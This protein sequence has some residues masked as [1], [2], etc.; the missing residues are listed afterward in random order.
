MFRRIDCNRR[1]GCAVRVKTVNYGNL[2]IMKRMYSISMLTLAAACCAAFTVNAQSGALPSS[3]NVPF[4][5]GEVNSTP[6][7]IFTNDQLTPPAASANGEVFSVA[8]GNWSDP[9]V[10]DC[11]CVPGITHDVTIMTG[12][13]VFMATSAAAVNLVIEPGGILAGSE[14]QSVELNLVGDLDNSGDFQPGNATVRMS[15]EV[16]QQIGGPIEI[17]ELSIENAAGVDAVGLVDV[18]GTLYVSGVLNT[19]DA[20][21]LLSSGVGTSANLAPVMGGTVNGQLT[22]ERTVQTPFA[23]WLT[24]GS[25]FTDATLEE[26]NDDFVTTGF[27]GSDFPDFSFVS[28]RTYNEEP[29]VG[30]ESFQSVSD[31]TEAIAPGEGYYLYSNPGTYTFDISGLPVIGNFTFPVSFTDHG[32]PSEDG[33]NLV[34]NPYA[35]NI[36][37]ASE[38]GW[39]KNNMHGV[40]YIWDVGLNQFRTYSNGYGVNGGSPLIRSGEAFWVHA[41]GPS[42]ELTV[43]ESAKVGADFDPSVN[44][45][46]QYL[47]FR[48]TGLGLGDEIIVAFD[49]NATEGF[50]P[51]I[52]AF[53]FF[54]SN[55]VI[56][57]A[58]VTPDGTRLAINNI[59]NDENPMSVPILITAAEAGT[60]TIDIQNLP[61][62]TNRCIYLE[63]LVNG[64]VFQLQEGTF[65]TFDTEEVENQER[66]LIHYSAPISA[67]KADITC[68]GAN[69]GSAVAEGVGVG[70]W[71]YLWLDGQGNIIAQETDV[72]A[73]STI[74]DLAAGDYT[75]SIEGNEVCG[76][77]FTSVTIEEPTE[78]TLSSTSTNPDCNEVGTGTAAV[79]F[80]GGTEPYVAQWEDGSTELERVDLDAGTYTFT[81][82]DA[83]GCMVSEEVV[84]E[85]A[86]TVEAAFEASSQVINLQEGSATVNFTNNSVNATTFEWDFGDGSPVSNEENPSHTYTAEGAYIV[87]LNASNEQCDAS[88]QF[89]I[90]VQEAV[91]VN[92]E[93]PIDESVQVFMNGE[94]TEV[95]FNHTDLRHYQINA[96]NLL[97][98][99]L[100]NPIEG[101]FGNQSLR[102]DIMDEVP[103]TLITIRN[104]QTQQAHTFKILR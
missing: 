26:W 61:N 60:V 38:S 10:W 9:W 70:P 44:E 98:Q 85:A 6:P 77:L 12:D 54:S 3:P 7:A 46:D 82:T 28:I 29:A 17:F 84:I 93:L 75:V 45:G 73:S 68:F 97:G 74:Q 21:R 92:E 66:F 59:P 35:S 69:D 91:S 87:S 43:S 2:M 49:E 95:R 67:E 16:P 71:S 81:V 48:M 19:N 101:N 27:T 55:A 11:G 104:T 32:L 42:P 80:A 63:D 72:M 4:P 65:I 33:L 76:A 40:I 58:T 100:L 64:D 41:N 20:V 25:P 103:V 34:A 39:T 83:N 53:K 8:S 57:L 36:S 30:S 88:T 86:P 47:K 37:W 1:R 90:V 31:V 78:L 15:G 50:D 94:Q 56:N 99:Q 22:L 24:L 51:G 18:I 14:A 102:L 89:V 96:Y 23:G 62:V 5:Q 52:D 13:S 79:E